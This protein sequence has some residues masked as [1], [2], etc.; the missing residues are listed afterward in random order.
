VKVRDVIKLVEGDGWYHVGTR[1]DHRQYEHP[2]KKG[3]MTIPGHPGNDMPP[4]TYASVL[5][6]GTD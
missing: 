3:R 4:K 6:H 2:T 1:G 5:K